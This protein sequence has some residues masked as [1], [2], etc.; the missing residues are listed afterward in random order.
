M[1]LVCG[2][3]LYI[4]RQP[5]HVAWD[6]ECIALQTGHYSNMS[7]VQTISVPQIKEKRCVYYLGAVH[8]LCRL[9]IGDFS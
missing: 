2:L 8:K 3:F 7:E 6:L 1:L 4:F 5:A 9:K